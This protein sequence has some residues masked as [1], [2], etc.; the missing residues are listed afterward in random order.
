MPEILQAKAIFLFGIIPS[1]VGLEVI[2]FLCLVHL[3]KPFK[4][5]KEG[6][7]EFVVSKPSFI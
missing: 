1:S 3:L 2:P 5:K 7:S 4:E 6:E